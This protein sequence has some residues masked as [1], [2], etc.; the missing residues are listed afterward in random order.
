VVFTGKEAEDIPTARHLTLE[1]PK[2]RGLAMRLPYFAPGQPVPNLSILGIA[3]EIKGFWSLWR[4]AIA[5]SGWKRRRLMP[6]FLAD[7]GK[8]YTP[9]ARHIWDQLLATN[10]VIRSTFAA[11]F[12]QA[13][14]ARLQK[15]AEEHGQP[16]YEALVQEHQTRI[17]CEREKADYAFAARCK[18]IERIGLP[19]VRS[20]RLNLLAEEEHTFQEQLERRAQP[21]PE[22]VPL[23]LI[24]VEGG[25]HE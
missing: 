1:D 3:N 25:D 24:R 18:A 21:Y 23:L 5:N 12:S 16:I 6:L 8:V 11:D 7:N 9:T 4:I 17:A 10:P 22:M 20:H 15:A 19:Q 2:V 13:S 14:F